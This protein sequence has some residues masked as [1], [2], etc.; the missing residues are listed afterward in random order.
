MNFSP[1]FFLNSQF[2]VLEV[3]L[4]LI[5]LVLIA[6]SVYIYRHRDRNVRLQTVN[7]LD[8]L[9]IENDLE[10]LS[11]NIVKLVLKKYEFSTGSFFLFNEPTKVLK[12][13]LSESVPST[14][15]EDIKN[16]VLLALDECGVEKNYDSLDI[17]LSNDKDPDDKKIRVLTDSI[18]V[19]IIVNE[20]LVGMFIFTTSTSF[21]TSDIDIFELY[22]GISKRLGG[23][24]KFFEEIQEGKD[25]FE[26]LINSIVSPV[27]MIGK[28]FELI[29][30]NPSFEKLFKLSSSSDFNILDFSNKMPKSIKI[31]KILQD[32]FIGGKVQKFENI[33]ID[34]YIY[35]VNFFPV[36]KSNKVMAT[37]ILFQ[38]V[39]AEYKNEKLRQEFVAMLV[40]DLRSPLTVIK[41]GTDLILSRYKDLTQEKMKDILKRNLETADNLLN[42]VSDLLDTYKMDLNKIQIFKEVVDIN[43]IIKEEAKAFEDQIEAKDLKLEFELDPK[44]KKIAVDKNKFK[45]VVQNLVSNAVKY[46]EKGKILVKTVMLENEVQIEFSDTGIGISD[47]LKGKLFNKF[48]QLEDS[49]KR[50]TKSTGLG[51]VVVKGILNA[52]NS[53]ISVHNNKPNGTIF[54]IN[55][56]IE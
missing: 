4:I 40:H 25:K 13:Y 26:D 23:I 17:V 12:N 36:I 35:D 22:E 41:S 21:R 1:S 54:R 47:E 51:L 42:I 3:G 45:Q 50:K 49:L 8:S 37:S 15:I 9:P 18:Q 46:T 16:K 11:E 32:V 56:P 19:P 24:S 52:H 44:V 14:Y 31:E 34:G 20:V 39:S 27:C 33:E 30:L 10:V 6:Y 53:K 5:A 43:K 2:S 38:E 7:F 29:Y 48:T 28:S 55:I